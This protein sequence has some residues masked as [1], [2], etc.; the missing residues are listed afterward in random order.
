MR[1]LKKEE[2][3]RKENRKGE[4]RRGERRRGMKGE[5]ENKCSTKLNLEMKV[6]DTI[7]GSQLTFCGAPPIFTTKCK[8]DSCWMFSS[9]KASSSSNK[10]FPL[11][12]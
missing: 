5:G 2:R 4:E 1:M 6:K 8:V 9:D 10:N 7:K 3:G 11:Q 12:K